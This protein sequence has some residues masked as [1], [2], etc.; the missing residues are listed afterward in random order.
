MAGETKHG[1]Q[2][3]EFDALLADALDGTLR[4]AALE[5]FNGHR[6]QCAVCGPVFAEAEAGIR[7]LRQ[8]QDVDPPR[9]LVH[10]I[11]AATIGVEAIHPA[12]ARQNWL[13]RLRAW[14]PN[15]IAPLLQPRFAMSFGMAFFSITLLLNVV[16]IK[17]SDVRRLD[18]RPSAMVRGYHETTGK[19]VKYYENLRFVY[20]LESRVQQLKRAATPAAET[21]PSQEKNRQEKENKNPSGEPDKQKRNIS[22]EEDGPAQLA[23]SPGHTVRKAHA[24]TSRRVS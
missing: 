1:M 24:S 12:P 17:L 5:A 19:L 14:K 11:L 15:L 13:E 23:S 2:C 10:N 18:L 9:N 4:G 6:S 8:L 3:S 21:P 20:E 16:G 22:R 7:W